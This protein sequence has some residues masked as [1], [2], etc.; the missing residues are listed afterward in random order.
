[1]KI[2]RELGKLRN[3]HHCFFLPGK[4]RLHKNV[5]C[6]LDSS[7]R[8]LNDHNNAQ[9]MFRR[10][11]ERAP[12]FPVPPH[13]HTSAYFSSR[14][15]FIDLHLLQRFHASCQFS[16][17]YIRKKW[18]LNDLLNHKHSSASILSYFYVN[19]FTYHISIEHPRGIGQLVK[20]YSNV[21]RFAGSNPQKRKLLQT[22]LPIIS[23]TT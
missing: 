13:P 23:Q 1:M 20:P 5:S 9:A 7:K 4:P 19:A 14:T 21:R 15:A 16:Y 8:A 2:S 17:T 10:Y 12:Q 3:I 22:Y 11:F 18:I 6:S